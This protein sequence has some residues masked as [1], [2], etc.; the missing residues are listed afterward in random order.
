MCKEAEINPT[1]SVSRAGNGGGKRPD[2]QQTST[3]LFFSETAHLGSRPCFR[4]GG[5]GFAERKGEKDDGNEEKRTDKTGK[6]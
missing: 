2:R 1:G 4:A 6:A 3:D 5:S